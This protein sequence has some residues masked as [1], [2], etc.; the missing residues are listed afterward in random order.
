[1]W[2]SRRMSATKASV[3]TEAMRNIRV[4]LSAVSG[5]S[6]WTVTPARA[7]TSASPV[8]SITTLAV[9]RCMPDLLWMTTPVMVSSSMIGSTKTEWRYIS[10]PA[11]SIISN[12]TSFMTS[13]SRGV[14][15]P[16]IPEGLGRWPTLHRAARSD[17]T[18]DDLLRDTA[19]DRL[20]AIVVKRDRITQFERRATRM[21]EAFDEGRASARPW[22]GERRVHAGTPPRRPQSRHK[23]DPTSRSRSCLPSPQRTSASPYA[24]PKFNTAF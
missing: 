2:G 4:A 5:V 13:D 6:W 7:A 11:S 10:T 1:M 21:T 20:L 19:N 22:R 16:Q 15:V 9:S 17:H 3:S 24:Q 18:I 12:R 8:E 23:L 14:N